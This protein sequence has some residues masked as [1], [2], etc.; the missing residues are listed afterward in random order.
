MK[1]FPLVAVAAA[2]LVMPAVA[3]A[4]AVDAKTALAAEAKKP[5]KKKAAKVKK[6]KIEYMRAAP[7]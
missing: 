7:M 2:L 1:R 3:P 5:V 6:E 4:F